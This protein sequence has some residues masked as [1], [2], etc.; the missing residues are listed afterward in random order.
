MFESSLAYKDAIDESL[1]VRPLSVPTCSEQAVSERW[2]LAMARNLPDVRNPG[3]IRGFLQTL[4]KTM[5]DCPTQASFW[6][7]LLCK[8]WLKYFYPV[9]YAKNIS[10]GL[11]ESFDP[12]TVGF[13]PFCPPIVHVSLCMTGQGIVCKMLLKFL[14]QDS[15]EPLRAALCGDREMLYFVLDV[16]GEA[17]TVFDRTKLKTSESFVLYLDLKTELTKCLKLFIAEPKLLP[18]PSEQE[19][20]LNLKL[21]ACLFQLF[22]T[23]DC[24]MTLSVR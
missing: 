16:L 1:I 20:A 13:H 2:V 18:V 6:L 8:R 3:S 12:Q 5:E 23:D 22:D 14:R 17:Y 24:I 11:T 21:I 19:R 4:R 10:L 15:L 9:A 7:P